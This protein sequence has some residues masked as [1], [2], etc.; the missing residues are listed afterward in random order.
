MAVMACE[1]SST[2]YY[3][4]D[5]AMTLIKKSPRHPNF[6]ALSKSYF[7][8]V[9]YSSISRRVPFNK[10]QIGQVSVKIWLLNSRT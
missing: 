2:V 3:L 6:Q 1:T 10:I 5:P 7:Y 8:R 9:D 4:G